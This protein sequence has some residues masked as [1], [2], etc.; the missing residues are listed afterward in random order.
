VLQRAALR[1]LD[2]DKE[3]PFFLLVSPRA[4][5]GPALR[6]PDDRGRT[7]EFKLPPSYN[8]Q[9]VGDK[10][11][12]GGQ[13]SPLAP[14]EV[15]YIEGLRRDQLRSLLGVDRLIGTL[16]D[17]L[18]ADGRL[19]TTWIIFSS[20]NGMMLGEHR[21]RPGKA[22]AYEECVRVPLVI[23][24]PVGTSPPVTDDHLVANIDLAPTV[25]AML[26]VTPGAPVDGQ[27][28]L[29]LLTN[30]S[31]PW[32]DELLLEV[33]KDYHD[34]LAFRALRTPD[35]KYVRYD[36]DQEELYN[37]TA[38]PHELES[39]HANPELAELKADLARRLDALLT[40]TTR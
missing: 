26:G 29:P 35:W 38:D 23:I 7:F 5:H 20:D 9:D 25:A 28:L 4:P 30:P 37:Q 13:K 10:P 34:D 12:S 32:R 1:F 31:S 17:Q 16:V 14:S 24:P 3:R 40:S 11:P 21:W 36:N 39:Q 33:W 22:C 2:G 15:K 6:D 18:Q 19:D 8:E 27:S